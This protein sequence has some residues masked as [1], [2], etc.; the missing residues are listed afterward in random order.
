M[1]SDLTKGKSIY[2]IQRIWPQSSSTLSE[3][4]KLENPIL[5][6]LKPAPAPLSKSVGSPLKGTGHF[7]KHCQRLS[8]LHY[9]GRYDHVACHYS[10]YCGS[11][12]KGAKTAGLGKTVRQ[13]KNRSERR[14]FQV[15]EYL[16]FIISF[17][18]LMNLHSKWR[19]L[20]DLRNP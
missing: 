18:H 1:P 14:C 16:K 3:S 7:C 11:D 12:Q 17:F 13:L 20:G 15:A 8:W 6:D 10:V 2:E 4:I 9:E 5:K 19:V